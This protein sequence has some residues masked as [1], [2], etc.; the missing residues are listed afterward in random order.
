MIAVTTVLTLHLAKAIGVYAIAAGLGGVLA[1]RRW[2]EIVDGLR[3]DQA[4]IYVTGVLCFAIG[5][6]ILLVHNV[7]TDPLAIVITLLGWVVA[8]EGLLLLVLPE[9]LLRFASGL[10]LPGPTRVFSVIAL[11]FGVALVIAGLLGRAGPL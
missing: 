9:P 11:V 10:V 1:P 8:I 7:W 4:L 3:R 5:T 6:A 2:M